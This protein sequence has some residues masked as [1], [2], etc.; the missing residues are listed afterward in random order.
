MATERQCEFL[1][2]SRT[3]GFPERSAGFQVVGFQ[4][5]AG[6]NRVVLVSAEAHARV[7][8]RE[9]R[10]VL[11]HEQP[12]PVAAEKSVSRVLK[13]Q[14]SQRTTI[15]IRCGGLNEVDRVEAHLNLHLRDFRLSAEHGLDGIVAA[16]GPQRLA[17]RCVRHLDS[18]ERA[19]D[20]FPVDK[21]RHRD[22]QSR[23][24]GVRVALDHFVDLP[25]QGTVPGRR[26][27]PAFQQNRSTAVSDGE[28]AGIGKQHQPLVA[29]HGLRDRQPGSDDIR[30]DAV[31]F[32]LLRQVIAASDAE[33]N[34]GFA[35]PRG[36]FRHWRFYGEQLFEPL[37]SN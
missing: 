26:H 10:I 15:R 30:I 8:E 21:K 5:I 33:C 37:R 11:N 9:D 24:I 7:T 14:L 18:A 17:R 34:G 31:H 25:L 2:R 16:S 27:R 13:H 29:R 35:A 36:G 23:L 22:G 20:D 3:T 6:K 1:D 32:E 4:P 28:A 12:L 19:A